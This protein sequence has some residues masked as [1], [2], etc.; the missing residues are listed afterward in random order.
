MQYHV[1][2]TNCKKDIHLK[3]MCIGGRLMQVNF[4]LALQLAKIKLKKL[5]HVK[6]S[7]P[8]VTYWNHPFKSYK[9]IIPHYSPDDVCSPSTLSL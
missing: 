4:D 3:R 9:S 2:L 7:T 1:R 8:Y 5:N 6:E